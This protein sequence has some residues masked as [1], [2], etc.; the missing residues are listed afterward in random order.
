[1]KTTLQTLAF[2]VL[3]SGMALTVSSCNDSSSSSSR[4]SA[5]YFSSLVD[6]GMYNED[7]TAPSEGKAVVGAV[8]FASDDIVASMYIT[9]KD[10]EGTAIYCINVEGASSTY[11]SQTGAVTVT[12]QDVTVCDES[13]F[14]TVKNAS[15]SLNMVLRYVNG[16][17][18]Q[19][20]PGAE[21]VLDGTTYAVLNTTMK[22]YSEE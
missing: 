5:Q 17:T 2:A 10:I 14:D 13:T 22:M 4:S 1:M 15:G 8:L 16:S 21:L 6:V 18:A 19:I 20:E 12:L 7:Y 3:C 11:N 9:F